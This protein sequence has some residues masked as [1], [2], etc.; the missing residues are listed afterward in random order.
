MTLVMGVQ[1]T[2]RAGTLLAGLCLLTGV[3]QAIDCSGLPTTFTGNQFP[4]G[5]FFS[6]FD[7]PC[8]AIALGVGTGGTLYGDLNATYFQ[9]YFLVNPQYQL[10]VLGDFPNSRYFSVSLYDAHS[11]PSQSILDANIVPLTS[12][13]I[14][15]YEPGVAY[16][17]G[18]RY[19]VP[20]NFGGTPGTL[21]TG[22]M[23]NNFNVDVNGL[24]ATQRHPGMDWNSDKGFF[25]AYPNFQD[26]IVDTPQHTNPNTAGVVMVRAYLDIS[27]TTG[28][29]APHVIVRDVASG[30]AYPAAYVQSTLQMLTLSTTTG[31]PWLDTAQGNAHSFYETTYLPKLCFGTTES[32]SV[33]QWTR[34][35]EYVDGASPNA[36]YMIANVPAGLPATLASAGEVLR[37][38]FQIPTT[39]PTPCTDGCSRSGT[40]QMRYMS[41][42]FINPGGATIASLADSAFTQDATGNVTLIVG[43]GTTIP[44]WITP[45]NGYTYMDLTTLSGYQ[46]LNLLDLRQVIP[47]GGFNCAGQ[48]VPYRT[49]AATPAG[50]NLTGAYMPVVDYPVASSLPPV[51]A[52]LAGPTAWDVFPAGQPGVRP[53][54]GVFTAAPPQIATVVTQ[55]SA[56]GCNQFVAQATPPVTITGEN[57]GNFPN[58]IPFTGVSNYLQITDVTQNWSAGYTGNTCNV[59][60]TS[61]ATNRIQFV[62]NVDQN[63]ACP[64]VGGDQLNVQVW[65]PQTMVPA[66]STVTVAAN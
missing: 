21:Q 58:G 41:L 8:Y 19:A 59:S 49:A 53:T 17:S 55:C 37:I 60:M 29:T 46:Q 38:R 36:A 65:N 2:V 31:G 63:G 44:S 12:Q 3:A 5:N 56:P 23:M 61:W 51:A 9:A 32:Q 57:F 64:L 62:A 25:Q 1:Q 7:N 48:F 34:Q 14:N 30:C 10:I 47:S 6:N 13:Y 24:D 35:Q 50:N 4:T 39:P 15:P 27:P 40:E 26:H 43:T 22:C 18:Q 52:P 66:T 33:L 54:C 28:H 11:A 20:I 42:S 16:V 45:A